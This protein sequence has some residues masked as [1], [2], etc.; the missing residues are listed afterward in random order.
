[1]VR[2]QGRILRRGP[3]IH[4]NRSRRHALSFLRRPGGHRWTAG[5]PPDY[6][7]AQAAREVF[8]AGR[9]GN[10]LQRRDPLPARPAG[11]GQLLRA[12]PTP[13][14]PARFPH[15]LEDPRAGTLKVPMVCFTCNICGA[16]N[17]VERFA[18]EP[19]TCACGSNV[20]LRAL[21]HLLSLELFGRSLP[22]HGFPQMKAIRGLGMRDKDCYNGLLAE[23]FDYTNTF[24]D[25]EPRSEEHTSELQSLR[26]LV[27]RLLL[28][29][30]KC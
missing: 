7:H 21:I 28:E 10:D 29:K 9:R 16:Y 13:R 8:P 27:C 22:L 19:A 5:A 14:R 12:S 6:S 1:M 26:H 30:K 4:R 15:D 25:R 17:E 24:Y 3:G 20:R 2:R 11:R 23:K 18:S